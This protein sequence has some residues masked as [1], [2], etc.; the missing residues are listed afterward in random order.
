V[1][2]SA[3]KSLWDEWERTGLGLHQDTIRNVIDAERDSFRMDTAFRNYPVLGTMIER[4]GDG[5]YRLAPPEVG[6]APG[7]KDRPS[8][9]ITAGARGKRV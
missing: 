2:S 5:K 4:C 9:G 8:A 3:V 1:Q 7:V 6:Q